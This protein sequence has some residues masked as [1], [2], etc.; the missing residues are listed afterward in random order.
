[1]KTHSDDIM[2]SIVKTF[3]FKNVEMLNSIVM[4]WK[5]ATELLVLTIYFPA[6]KISKHEIGTKR[7]SLSLHVHLALL[8]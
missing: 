4:E 6:V 5:T 7:I 2:S 3:N 8:L 1:M